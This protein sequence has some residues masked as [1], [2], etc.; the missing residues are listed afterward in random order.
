MATGCKCR[1]ESEAKAEAL[2]LGLEGWEQ[3]PPRGTASASSLSSKT[4]GRRSSPQDEGGRIQL[5]WGLLCLPIA[6]GAVSP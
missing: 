4:L 1:K 3:Q 5:P 2:S 6:L